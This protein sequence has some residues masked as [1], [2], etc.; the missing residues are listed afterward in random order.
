MTITKPRM[1]MIQTFALAGLGLVPMTAGAQIESQCGPMFDA[2]DVEQYDGQA[3]PFGT[4]V[5]F[6]RRHE[7]AVGSVRWATDLSSRVANPGHIADGRRWCSGT[8]ID[9]NLF[10]TAGHCF[11]PRWDKPRDEDGQL[12]DAE[13]NALLMEVEF[14]YQKDPDGALRPGWSYPIVDLYEYELG[15][16]DYAIVILGDDENGQQPGARWPIA[17]MAAYDPVPGDEVTIIQHPNGV[18]KVVDSGTVA[19]T[20]SAE[21]H[22]GDLD[23]DG[24]SS[25]S[26][27][28]DWQGRVIGVHTNGGCNGRGSNR[29][30]KIE[31]IAAVSPTVAWRLTEYGQHSEAVAAG[32]FDGDG[33][34]DVA[35][36]LPGYS[37]FRDGELR[38]AAGGVYV[39]FGGPDGLRRGQ[40]LDQLTSEDGDFFGAAVAAGDFDDDGFVDLAVGVP[41]EDLGGQRDAGLVH[42]FEGGPNGL[43]RGP[44]WHQDSPSVVG[45]RE[46]GDR[47]GAA[48]AVGRFDGDRFDDLAIGVP[49]ESIS[50]AD[51]AGAVNVMYGSAAGITASGDHLWYQSRLGT[52]SDEAGDRFGASLAVGDFDGDGCDDLAVGH[53]GEAVGDL[54]QAGALS[55]ILGSL[56]G[57]TAVG[58]Q[59]WS[60]NTAGLAG[61]AEGGDRFAVSLAAG[62]LDDDGVDDLVVGV[63]GEGLSGFVN[64]GW[65]QVL[66]GRAGVGLDATRDLYLSQSSTGAPARESEDR[67]GMSVAVGQLDGRYGDDIVAGSPGEAIG[68]LANAGTIIEWR[69]GPDGRPLAMVGSSRPALD[70]PVRQGDRLG[71]AVALGDLN[72][73]GLDDALITV[74]GVVGGA[75]SPLGTV[76]VAVGAQGGLDIFGSESWWF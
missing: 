62:D 2:Q 24:G 43:E 15:G 55:V 31:A 53:P 76:I 39:W 21:I 70:G 47:F 12:L 13:G 14:E 32:D 10:L 52:G 20:D 57:T 36:A 49:G 5:E 60:Q 63:P 17:R 22:Y 33:F 41:G 48:L 50:G 7:P 40:L 74:P 67:L 44:T 75:L 56:Q 26:G 9:D 37:D 23:T 27:V 45:T 54:K 42:I 59:R 3:G 35:L 58:A 68:A 69:S 30:A 71:S 16:L 25:G 8:L 73:D 51:N 66:F 19:F 18:P 29:G 11:G 34:D 6:V 72:A 64:N 4:S 65:L 61:V 38:D 1:R 28:L 46:A